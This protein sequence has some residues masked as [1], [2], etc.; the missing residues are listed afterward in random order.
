[1]SFFKFK[2]IWNYCTYD[3]RFLALILLFFCVIVFI[4][5]YYDNLNSTFALLVLVGVDVLLFGYGMLIT[6]DRI[7][8]GIRLPKI[9]FKDGLILGIQSTIVLTILV[10]VQQFI[11]YLISSP[12]NF[13]EFDLEDMLMN[14]SK[15]LHTLFSHD[16]VDALIFVVLGAILFYITTFF[17]EIALARLADT[18]SLKSAFNMRGIKRDIDAIGWRNYAKDYTGIVL[19]IVIFS[20]FSDIVIPFDILNYVWA[21]FIYMLM[22][23]TQFWGIGN[24]YRK[25]KEKEKIDSS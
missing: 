2:S 10:Y 18:G 15:T 8:G 6:R 13:P 24:I 19:T 25:I 4:E 3:K 11:M 7:N 22:F 20:Y 1:M 21:V 23:A 14:Y 12:L 5:Q 17:V 9:I 16:P